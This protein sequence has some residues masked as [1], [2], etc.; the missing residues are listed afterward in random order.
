MELWDV[1]VSFDTE[2]F[3]VQVRGPAFEQQILSGWKPSLNS[4]LAQSAAEMSKGTYRLLTLQIFDTVLL[5][6]G[7][8]I[9][10]PYSWVTRTSDCQIKVSRSRGDIIE[11]V[12][13]DLISGLLVLSVCTSAKYSNSTLKKAMTASQFITCNLI[14]QRSVPAV[15]TVHWNY[16]VFQPAKTSAIIFISCFLELEGSLLRFIFTGLLSLATS[17]NLCNCWVAL[18]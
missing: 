14:I 6:A 3:W 16:I 15:S 5:F 9:Y 12:S 10:V 13:S 18:K 11:C 1:F 8:V 7:S 2:R 4:F 17:Y